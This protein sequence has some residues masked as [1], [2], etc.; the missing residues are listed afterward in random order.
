MWFV[1]RSDAVGEVVGRTI[2]CHLVRQVCKHPTNRRISNH[3]SSFARLGPTHTRIFNK[4][5]K[6]VTIG[7]VQS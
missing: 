1:S 6:G 4:L 5:V 2:A 7:I 3:N